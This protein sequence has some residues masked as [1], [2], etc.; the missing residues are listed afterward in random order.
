MLVA[1]IQTSRRAGH[2]DDSGIDR[3]GTP[4]GPV[5]GIPH[6]CYRTRPF[7]LRGICLDG[8][9]GSVY[10]APV[11]GLQTAAGTQLEPTRGKS[12]KG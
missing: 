7:S 8:G 9:E 1:E 10:G 2:T 12:G 6:V 11:L 5:T 3:R 4:G